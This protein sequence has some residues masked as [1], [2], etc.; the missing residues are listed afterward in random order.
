MTAFFLGGGVTLTRQKWGHAPFAQQHFIA[1]NYAFK[2]GAWNFL[3]DGIFT[4][5]IFGWDAH[6]GIKL[7]QPN[8]VLNFYG[9]GNNTELTTDDRDFNRVRVKQALARAGIQKAFKRHWFMFEGEFLSTKVESLDKRFVAVGNSAID[10]SDFETTNW[11]GGVAGYTVSTID[12]PRF[13]SRGVTFNTNIRYLYSNQQLDHLWNNESNFSF[14]IPIGKLVF[15]SRLGGAALSGE[16]QF[17]QYNQLGGTVNLRGYRRSRFAGK[18]SFYNNNELRIP[19]TDITGYIL[20]GKFGLTLFCDNGRVWMPNE[21][22]NKWHVGYGGGLWIIPFGRIAFTAH[23]GI[24]REEN[25]VTVR[26][27]F[28]F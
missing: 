17:F 6:V 7:N 26:T 10:S 16:P 18:F 15:A 20:R 5:A 4:K 24:S 23:Y 19:I 3:Y 8:Y 25:I 22:S 13:P 1:G 28:L 9:L 14:F 21:D 27:G 11:F 12:N 2:T